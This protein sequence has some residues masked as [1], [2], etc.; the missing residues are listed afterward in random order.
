MKL[1]TAS[2]RSKVARRIFLL[3]V[4]CALLPIAALAYVTLQ[5]VTRHLSLQSSRALQQASKSQSM[6]IYDRLQMLSSAL[7]GVPPK[8][9][10]AE[11]LAL[12]RR[13]GGRFEGMTIIDG[14]G[15]AHRIFGATSTVRQLTAEE[16]QHLQSGK[17][18][19]VASP[20]TAQAAGCLQMV[21]LVDL[22]NSALLVGELNP[23]YLWQ[24]DSLSFGLELSAIDSTKAPLFGHR[25]VPPSY[26]DE[27]SGYRGSS[28]FFEW[29]DAGVLYDAAYWSLLLKPQF[30]AETWTIVV[31]QKHQDVVAPIEHFRKTFPYIVLLA[32]WIVILLSL[33][34]LRRTLVPLEK[35]QEG[36]RQISTQ[37]FDTRVEVKSGDEFQD[38]A[39]SFNLMTAR[40]G[41]QFQAL[42][43]INEIDQGIL[44]SLNR[45]GIVDAVLARMPD[46]LP[47]DCFCIAQFAAANSQ[48]SLTI[49]RA[50]DPWKEVKSTR[51]S[52]SD[53]GRMKDHP[54]VWFV[55][56]EMDAP[57]FL[58]PLRQQGMNS[59]LVLPIFLENH[60]FAALV[61]AHSAVLQW[62]KDDI[63][64]A[65]QVADQL[66]VAFSNVQLIEAMEHLHWG[67]LTALA[68]A[69]DA[70]SA[71][72]AG[73]S[74]RVTAMALKI[75]S[76]IGLPS[77]EL[78]IMHRGGL[79]HDIGKI[80]TPPDIL[81]KPEK[82]D[83]SEMAVMREH[84]HIGMRILEPIPGFKEALP[85]VAQHHEWFNGGGYPEGLAGENI[86]LH[87]RIFA[88]ADCYDALI[89]D[90][91][92]RTGL[93]KAK[94]IEILK[95]GSGVQFDPKVIEAFLRLC[96][97]EQRESR[98]PVAEP[99]IAGHMA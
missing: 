32:L 60:L 11:R 66:A 97:E 65:R 77:R 33:V 79:L 82:L 13:L 90:R 54:S 3:F 84:V 18:L 92:Y 21:R 5:Q 62:D 14:K 48:A 75:G 78:Q 63:Q 91:P 27:S 55:D 72:T 73:H 10:E 44:A 59:F 39:T 95:S 70:K 16:N 52:E 87:A 50:D 68:R 64:Q 40:L 36:T 80:G 53:S 99:A 71:W 96:E 24:A 4:L 20:C 94:V 88:V 7:Q 69:I 9:N 30:G 6:A 98:E 37:N 26:G 38:L 17:S 25:V 31:T 85:I 41:R 2:L 74:E 83:A 49:R 43:T 22:G 51:L 67:T 89:S 57:A 35:L 58:L 19:L 15:P 42:K 45:E 93:P 1:Q 47:C 28:R 34:H 81:D 23:D 56:Q 8:A 76:A 61:A 86:S 12:E 29:Q 46:L